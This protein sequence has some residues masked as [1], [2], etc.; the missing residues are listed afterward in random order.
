[1]S[2]RTLSSFLA[3]SLTLALGA[4]AR[5][6]GLEG[7]SASAGLSF[8]K[9]LAGAVDAMAPKDLFA[10]IPECLI[11]D[12]RF[13]RAPGL[14]EA[15]DMLRPCAKALTRRAAVPVSIVDPAGPVEASA[16][17]LEVRLGAGA[18]AASAF[19]RDLRFSLEKREHSLLGYPAKIVR[20]D[21]KP[22]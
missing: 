22:L 6:A 17:L 7:V 8:G 5:A 10:E 14:Q 11:V 12:A 16:P 13:I 9:E 4:S 1:M 19:M 18:L 21:W 3:L 20:G 15:V 2:N